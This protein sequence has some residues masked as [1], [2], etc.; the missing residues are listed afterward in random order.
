MITR[1]IALFAAIMP[2]FLSVFGVYRDIPASPKDKPGYTLIFD[3]EF[4]GKRIA[5]TDESPDYEMCMLL[6][7]YTRCDWDGV[8]NEVYPKT[9]SID[10][11]RVYRKSKGYE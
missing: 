7:L 11:I 4:D 8:D 10:Y 1:V 3:D 2:L 5:H 9:F 6:G